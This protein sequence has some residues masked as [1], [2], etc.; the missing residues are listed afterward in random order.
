[1]VALIVALE[2]DDLVIVVL[3]VVLLGG[4]AVT[5][6]DS[7]DQIFEMGTLAHPWRKDLLGLRHLTVVRV[8]FRQLSTFN[9]KT[10]QS[11]S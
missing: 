1:M 11:K 7:V 10:T 5:I 3:V 6:L 9:K 8:F 4:L 2:E